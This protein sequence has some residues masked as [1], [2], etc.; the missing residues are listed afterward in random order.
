MADLAA[1]DGI[2]GI[3]ATPHA[4]PDFH[5]PASDEAARVAQEFKSKLK[6][7]GIALEIWLGNDAHLVPELLEFLESGNVRTLNDSRYVLTEPSEYF[8]PEDLEDQLFHIRATGYVPILTHP[9]RYLIFIRN[10][11]FAESLAAQ[12]NLLQVTA[13]SLL[14]K[15]G[16]EALAFCRRLASSRCLH[17]LASDAHSARHRTPSLSAAYHVLEGWM[18]PENTHIARENARAVVEDREMVPF[19]EPPA[20]KGMLHRLRK[21]F[22]RPPGR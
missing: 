7:A 18:G 4:Y 8:M 9:E 13:G 2:T 19:V 3:V 12:G 1:K 16:D 14:G 22:K 21:R 20:P 11:D 15:F 10:P 6:E 17:F 5:F